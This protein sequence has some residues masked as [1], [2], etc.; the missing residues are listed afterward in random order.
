MKKL[1]LLTFAAALTSSSYA[2]TWDFST[3]TVD[4]PPLK[5]LT[6]TNG[7]SFYRST[8]APDAN[9]GATQFN[10]LGAGYN[11]A[12]MVVTSATVT[13]WFAD[14]DYDGEERVDIF[15][16]GTNLTGTKVLSNI[17]VNGT[18][19]QSSYASYSAN[20]QDFAGLIA[21]LQDGIMEYEVRLLNGGNGG[22]TYL[23][24]A[25]ISAQ[26][27]YRRVPDGGFSIAMLGAALAGLFAA[28]KRLGL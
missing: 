26:G 20:L 8:A 11:P 25:T 15:V 3:Q 5:F 7:N 23:K 6:G 16:N 18:H 24:I 4:A 19:P 17:E 14:D 21:A 12:T 1:L 10:L 22:D 27:N 9:G 13:F 28:R 2:I